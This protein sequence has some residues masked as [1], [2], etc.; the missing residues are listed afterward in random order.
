VDRR[1][2]HRLHHLRNPL[3]SEAAA[4]RFLIGT[5]IYLALIAIAAALGGPWAGLAVFVVLTTG[6]LVWAFRG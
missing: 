2:L 6:V 5:G 1:L 3:R 4:F